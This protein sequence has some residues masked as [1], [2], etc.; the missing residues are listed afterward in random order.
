MALEAPFFRREHVLQVP[1]ICNLVSPRLPEEEFVAE[2]NINYSPLSASEG[3][4]LKDP[5]NCTQAN[6]GDSPPSSVL[7]R[8]ALKFDPSPPLEETKEYYLSAPDN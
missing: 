1:G 4:H 7:R 6:E 5:A 8:S 3:Q 2:E